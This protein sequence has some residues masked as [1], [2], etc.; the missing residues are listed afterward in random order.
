LLCIRTIRKW[1]VAALPALPRSGS[2]GSAVDSARS[3]RD[4]CA[5]DPSVGAARLIGRDAQMRR[6]ALDQ[7]GGHSRWRRVLAVAHRLAEVQRVPPTGRQ[8]VE[9]SRPDEQLGWGDGRDLAG[10]LVRLVGETLVGDDEPER[11]PRSSLRGRVAQRR[12]SCVLGSPRRCRVARPTRGAFHR[13][14]RRVGGPA[15][16]L[17]RARLWDDTHRDDLCV[18]PRRAP[19]PQSRSRSRQR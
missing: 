2:T 1:R 6:S 8:L 4:V 12:R 17:P 19:R 15:D 11:R 10:G 13:R 5:P 9:E 16:E 3:C 18:D 14:V 7:T